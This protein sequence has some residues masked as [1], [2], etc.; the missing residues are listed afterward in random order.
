MYIHV[1][2]LEL[3][4]RTLEDPNVGALLLCALIACSANGVHEPTRTAP[5]SVVTAK[6]ADDQE[7]LALTDGPENAELRPVFIEPA[8]QPMPPGRGMTYAMVEREPWPYHAVVQDTMQHRNGALL[9]AL[10]SAQKG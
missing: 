3:R 8:A 7:Q 1:L 4:R 10:A 2:A 6:R 5:S 9:D